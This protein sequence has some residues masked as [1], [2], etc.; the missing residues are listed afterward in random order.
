MVIWAMLEDLYYKSNLKCLDLWMLELSLVTYVNYKIFHMKVYRHHIFA[1][2]IYLIFC[3]SY[4]II[5]FIIYIKNI[6]DE[7]NV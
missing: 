4:K 1:I 6:K 2:F 3:T 7:K 5:A